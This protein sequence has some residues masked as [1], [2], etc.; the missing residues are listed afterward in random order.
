M[1]DVATGKVKH[2]Q[3]IQ[4]SLRMPVGVG[5]RAIDDNMP[6]CDKDDHRVIFHA[7]SETAADEAG[8]DDGE[9]QLVGAEEGLGN[10]RC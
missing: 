3:S 9:G 4:P 10:G 2:A 6:E 7:V 5:H 8:G 1:H